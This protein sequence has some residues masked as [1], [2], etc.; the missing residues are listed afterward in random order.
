MNHIYSKMHAA[1]I[2]ITIIVRFALLL[3]AILAKYLTI[4]PATMITAK[5]VIALV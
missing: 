5:T 1:I 3:N 4:E 2:A